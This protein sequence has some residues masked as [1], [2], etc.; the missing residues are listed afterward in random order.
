MSQTFKGIIIIFI[1]IFLSVTGNLYPLKFDITGKVETIRKDKVITLLFEKKPSGI[2]YIIIEDELAA[3]KLQIMNVTSFSKNNKIIYRALARYS[4]EGN[5][6]LIKAGSYIGLVRE[7]EEKTP[8]LP[9]EET[10]KEK[11]IFKNSIITDTDYRKMILIPSGKFIFGS[12]NGDRDEKPQQIIL[13][14]DYYIDKYEVSNSDY[15]IFIK[16]TNSKPPISWTSGTYNKGE[17][18]FPVIVSYYEAVKYAEWAGKNLPTEEEWEK[19]ARGTG[20]EYI[21][22]PDGHYVTIIKPVIYP[23]GNQFD[24]LKTNSIEFWD[25]IN[26]TNDFKK[27]YNKGLLPVYFSKGAGDS[28]Y[29]IVNLSGNAAEWTSSWYNAYKGSRY[30]DK[31]FGRQVKV[32]R[33]GAWFYTRDKVRTTNREI[34]GLPNL[35]EDNIAGFRCVKEPT[36]VDISNA[37]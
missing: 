7:D 20:I 8:E 5:F 28:I 2:T 9:A 26:I 29:G 27:K 21:K 4:A 36:I 31:M 13:M 34:G 24:S 19:A 17:E 14:D 22:D 12:D 11:K 35:Y 6:D 30:S 33:G 3:G 37:N 32:I 23:W 25:D 18:D 15:D 10:K 1:I 16:K